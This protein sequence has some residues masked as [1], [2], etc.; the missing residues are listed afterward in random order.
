M[1]I[2]IDE[3]LPIELKKEFSGYEVFTVNDMNWLGKKN[4]ELLKLAIE[5]GFEIFITVDKNLKYQ[6]NAKKFPIGIIVLD[7][8]RTKI[9]FIKPLIGKV[10]E[11]VPIIKP[12]EIYE[13][14]TNSE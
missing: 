4:G 3:S 1:K 11:K 14:K 6:L 8:F 7:I 13:I 2:L 10:L 5:N 12:H 9:E